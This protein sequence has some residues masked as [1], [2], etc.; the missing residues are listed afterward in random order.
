MSLPVVNAERS[1][2]D[3]FLRSFCGPSTIDMVVEK[4]MQIHR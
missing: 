1:T 4:T 2:V 3:Y